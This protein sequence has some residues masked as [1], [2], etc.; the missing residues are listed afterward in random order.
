MS[1]L[2]DIFE[3]RVDAYMRH[4]NLLRISD[5]RVFYNHA[6]V[7]GLGYPR[8]PLFRRLVRKG[9]KL[10]K[11]HTL[12]AGA[13]VELQSTEVSSQNKSTKGIV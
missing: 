11:F 1:D 8:L 4:Q 5:S 6:G 13:A 7:E 2:G 10:L 9:R 12:N 3:K